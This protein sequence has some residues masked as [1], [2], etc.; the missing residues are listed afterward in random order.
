MEPK[1]SRGNDD[2]YNPPLKHITEKDEVE[3]LP[4]ELAD[5]KL[6]WNHFNIEFRIGKGGVG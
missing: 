2:R 3:D 5:K 1:T 6:K 4:E